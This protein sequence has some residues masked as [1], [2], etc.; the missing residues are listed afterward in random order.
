MQ[1]LGYEVKLHRTK[2]GKQVEVDLSRRF[3]RPAKEVKKEIK[4]L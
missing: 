1:L 4:R 2:K 3:I